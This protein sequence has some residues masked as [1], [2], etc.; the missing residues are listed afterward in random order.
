[1]MDLNV[2]FSN[3]IDLKGLLINSVTLYIDFNEAVK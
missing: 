2:Q 3:L 1:M